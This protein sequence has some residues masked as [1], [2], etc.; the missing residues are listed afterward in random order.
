MSHTAK[1]AWDP[2]LYAEAAT[3]PIRGHDQASGLG[4]ETRRASE[5]VCLGR[6]PWAE[7][8]VPVRH[9]RKLNPER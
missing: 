5:R 8:H 1:M 4:V 2:V 7:V 3:C 9:G 6:P